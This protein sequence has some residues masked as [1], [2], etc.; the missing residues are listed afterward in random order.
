MME[1]RASD[2]GLDAILTAPGRNARFADELGRRFIPTGDRLVAGA[3]EGG[4]LRPDFSG[5]EVCFLG[6]MVG[7]VA[8]I[9]RESNPEVWRRCA[10]L[11]IDGTR[12]S[13]KTRPRPGVRCAVP[14]GTTD[15]GPSVGPVRSRTEI[16]DRID[17]IIDR[18][19]A[20]G[21]R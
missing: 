4:E 7:K 13:E 3:V 11:L 17:A 16:R 18:V 2:R 6:F 19:R 5:Q 1:K 8:D 10:Q 21:N 14:W 20:G 9:T 12:P 15:E